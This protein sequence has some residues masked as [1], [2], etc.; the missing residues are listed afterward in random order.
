M[1]VV[2]HMTVFCFTPLYRWRWGRYDLSKRRQSLTQLTSQNT[3]MLR[4]YPT[5]P[6]PFFECFSLS[7]L[8]SFAT[9]HW[10]LTWVLFWA[11]TCP[12]G[13]HFCPSTSVSL[14]QYNTPMLH[15]DWFSCKE[16]C[17]NSYIFWLLRAYGCFKPTFR[18]HHSHLQELS[19]PRR[20]T[21][22]PLNM[23]SICSPDTS[24][25]KHLTPR[26]NPEDRV[27]QF[28]NHAIL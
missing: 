23:G 14:C 3:S 6:V 11:G 28:N 13:T 22:W 26:N 5:S 12:S 21:A 24:V 17:M 20:R 2:W 1:H 8:N 4:E 9:L 7:A 25:W 10:S 16:L 27:T 15:T 19:C 18:G